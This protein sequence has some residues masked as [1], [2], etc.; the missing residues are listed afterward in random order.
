MKISFIAVIAVGFLATAA[1]ITSVSTA[2]TGAATERRTTAKT[3]PGQWMWDEE[4]EAGTA[5]DA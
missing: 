5:V 2:D 4:S 1:V 3:G